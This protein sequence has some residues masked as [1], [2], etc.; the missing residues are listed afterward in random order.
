M[1]M[2]PRVLEALDPARATLVFLNTRNQA[3]RWYH[4]IRFA[5]PEWQSVMALHHGSIDRAERE[6]VEAGLKSGALRIVVATSSLDLGVDF[7]P[8]ERVFQIGSA[9]GV[10]RL[11]QRAGR[12]GHRPGE[13]CRVVCVPTHGLELVEIAAARDAAEHGVMEPRL[14]LSKPLDVLAQHMVTCSLGGGF[15]P[16]DLFAEV[17]TAWSYRDLTRD[18]FDWTLALVREGGGTLRAY[19]D[20]HRVRVIDTPHGKRYQHATGGSSRLAHLHRLNVGTITSDGTLDLCY[21]NGRRLGSIEE[22]FVSNLAPGQKFFFA[23]KV[24]AFLGL[25]DLTAYVAPAR[26]PASLTPIWSG[27]RLPIS[28]SLGLAVRETLARIAIGDVR[29]PEAKAAVELVSTQARVSR[30]P[31]ADEVLAEITHTREGLHLFVFPFDGRLVHAGLAAIIAL[32]L[33]RAKRATFLTAANDYGFELVTPDTKFPLEEL[34]GATSPSGGVFTTD[35][36]LQDASE[37][38]AQAQLARLQFREIARISGLVF[39]TH[40]GARKTARQM[41]AS[42]SLIFDVFREFDPENLLLEQAR[43][44][45]MERQF[46]QTRL[47]RTVQ[48]IASSKLVLVNTPC[49]TPLSL[50]LILERAAAKV[51]TETLLER[52]NRMRT[53][54]ESEPQEPQ[55]PEPAGKSAAKKTRASTTKAKKTRSRNQT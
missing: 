43:R 20:Y 36:L 45:V 50:P 7:S 48:R 21:R 40:P 12:S 17:R 49:P 5:K 39:Q 15:D 18:E 55:P 10:S 54:W 34:L 28:E 38:I 33:A 13:P 42:S 37:G 46:E 41:Q 11:L 51:S 6:R 52:F 19:P 35:R 47:S 3:E 53:A 26:G 22:H 30:V 24:L 2:L 8:V 14:P 25:H 9:K 44:E 1:C 32:R 16:D 31:R 4:A 23:G 27:T 29:S